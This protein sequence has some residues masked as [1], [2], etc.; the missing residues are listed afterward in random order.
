MAWESQG[1][2]HGIVRLGAR[3]GRMDMRSKK[4]SAEGIG[5]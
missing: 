2:L 3:T 4:L 1:G 5:R